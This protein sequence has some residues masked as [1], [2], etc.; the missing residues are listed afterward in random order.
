LR[1]RRSPRTGS[2]ASLM[3]TGLLVV[4]SGPSGVGKGRVREELAAR[5]PDLVYAVSATT[6]P[7]RP[8]EVDGVHYYFLSEEEFQRRLRDGEFV[9]WARVYGHLYGTPGEPVRRLLGE[10]RTVIMEKDVQGARTLRR[11]FPEAVFV[12]LLPPSVEELWRRQ[13]GRA[14]ETEESLAV[15]RR[16]VAVELAEVK[17]YDYAVVNDDLEQAVSTVRAIITA[18]RCRVRRVLPDLNSAG[19]ISGLRG[20]ENGR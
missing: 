13:E 5:M 6:R 16:A 19:L 2:D 3:G 11:V 15:R 17:W 1:K 7:P 9:E 8:G 20:K 18:E 10:G 4:L 12:F 14:T